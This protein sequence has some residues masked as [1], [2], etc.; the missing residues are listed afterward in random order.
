MTVTTAAAESDTVC[1]AELPVTSARSDARPG[2]SP[3]ISNS[4]VLDAPA[5]EIKTTQPTGTHGHG[6]LA[7]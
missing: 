4:N 5:G 6:R 1:P 2:F 3:L 7:R